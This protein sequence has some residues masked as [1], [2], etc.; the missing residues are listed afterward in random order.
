MTEWTR[1][2]RR[3]GE[4]KRDKKKWIDDDV[5]TMLIALMIEGRKNVEQCMA[6]ID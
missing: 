2:T 6:T 1:I 3:E 4:R 5:P